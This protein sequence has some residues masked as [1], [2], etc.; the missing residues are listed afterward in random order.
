MSPREQ[1][2]DFVAS[3]F[4]IPT[5][6]RTVEAFPDQIVVELPMRSAVLYMTAT[7][8]KVQPFDQSDRW[9][10]SRVDP[11]H[12]SIDRQGLGGMRH[13]K[14]SCSGGVAATTYSPMKGVREI[15]DTV[16]KVICLHG[17]AQLVGAGVGDSEGTART[18]RRKTREASLD[19]RLD[20]RMGRRP[21]KVKPPTYV[22][23]LPRQVRLQLVESLGA[24][25]HHSVGAAR[26]LVG[27]H[28]ENGR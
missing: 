23:V 14:P 7:K 4:G 6:V 19:V 25:H 18:A 21:G 10:V 9:R 13:T 27:G 11:N 12:E 15:H 3:S 16:A 26:K 8:P 20:I 22:V 5:R 17:A 28:A 1:F 24:D 2:L